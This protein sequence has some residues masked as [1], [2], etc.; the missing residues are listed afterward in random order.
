MNK[1][2]KTVIA[3]IFL[4]ITIVYPTYVI[5]EGTTDDFRHLIEDF[6]WNQTPE[7]QNLLE[8]TTTRHQTSMYLLIGIQLV[9]IAIFSALIL[10]KEG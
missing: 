9:C 3:C 6:G 5:I 4:A 1:K 2:V 8:T 10:P 7:G